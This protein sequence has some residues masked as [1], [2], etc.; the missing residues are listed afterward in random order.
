MGNGVTTSNTGPVW[1]GYLRSD[2][3]RGIRNLVLVVHTVECAKFVAEAIAKDEPDVHVIGFSG[4]YDNQYAIRLMLAL[5]R[6]PNVGAVLAVGLGCEYTQ[7]EKIA[8]VVRESGRPAEWFYI[9]DAGGTRTGVE[10]GKQLVAKLREQIA[11][12]PRVEMRV[13]DLTIGCEC[14]GSDGTS[15]LAGNPVVGAFFDQLVDSGGRAIFEEIVEMIGLKQ[16]M[17]ARAASPMA[18]EQIA[19]AY[20]KAVRYCQDVRQYSVSPGNFAG[21]LTTI[22]EKS[23][24]A[25]AK[26]GTRA[27]QGVIKVAQSPPAPGL[28]LMDSVPD[29]HFMGFGYTNPNDTEGIMDLISG[30]CQIVLFVTG[31]GSVIGSPVAP[32][33]KVTGNSQTYRRMQDDM[34]FDAGRVLT[35]ERTLLEAATE[36]RDLIARVA[37]GEP[38]KPEALGHRE[39]FVMYK[40][41]D[42]PSLEAGCRA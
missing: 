40:H 19:A 16:I 14:G 9:Q 18:R 8:E 11:N 28:W 24:G 25:F 10:R 21:G 15:G 17:L 1:Q 5:A 7:P 31:R 27:I 4:C 42:T 39:Y 33:I 2:G 13:S 22:E 34:D 30:G 38:S 32:L 41:Q 35:G 36:L 23:M 6:H 29:P 3:R 26:S 12:T 20:D 37:A